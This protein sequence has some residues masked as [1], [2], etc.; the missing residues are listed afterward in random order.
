[1]PRRSPEEVRWPR[2]LP[3]AG[4]LAELALGAVPVWWGLR[5]APRPPLSAFLS[6]AGQQSS[7]QVGGASVCGNVSPCSVNS[8]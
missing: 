3:K 2:P 6:L 5:E 1:M 8:W 4:G 7:P